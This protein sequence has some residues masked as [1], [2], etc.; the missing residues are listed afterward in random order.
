MEDRSAMMS[1]NSIKDIIEL[2]ERAA[3]DSATYAIHRT[4]H[5][6]IATAKIKYLDPRCPSC[7]Q[8]MMG[9]K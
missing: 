1:T 4:E 7:Q 9:G 5:V 8:H 6:D 2:A 3:R